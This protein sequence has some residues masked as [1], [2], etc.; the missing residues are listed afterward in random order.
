M[1]TRSTGDVEQP[2]AQA[3]P[4]PLAAP[5]LELGLIDG[6]YNR[7]FEVVDLHG[8]G[9]PARVRYFQIPGAGPGPQLVYEEAVT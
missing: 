6:W 9:R 4:V 3:Y 5:N 8:A 1:W 2:Y 7:G